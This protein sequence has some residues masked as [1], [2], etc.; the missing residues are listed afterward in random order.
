[1][2]ELVPPLLPPVLLRPHCSTTSGQ[3]PLSVPTDAPFI[4]F[5]HP[6]Y[7]TGYDLMFRLSANDRCSPAAD[8]DTP[9][10]ALAPQWGIHHGTALQACT[11]VACNLD[12]VLSPVRLGRQSDVPVSSPQDVL[13]ESSYWFYP[14]GWSPTDEPYPVC[15][16]FDNWQFPHESIPTDWM[17]I[18]VCIRI[19]RFLR[20]FVTILHLTD[21][22]PGARPAITMASYQ[23]PRSSLV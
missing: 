5:R 6:G 1:M 10:P 7:Q 20:F 23:R 11:I 14:R 22:I 16:D 17:A 3:L 19:H 2:S 8:T 13:T 4:Q 18:A 12:G 9:V 21:F 15:P